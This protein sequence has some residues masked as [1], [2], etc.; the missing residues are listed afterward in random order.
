MVLPFLIGTLSAQKRFDA[1][2]P[3]VYVFLMVMALMRAWLLGGLMYRLQPVPVT[4]GGHIRNLLMLQA[5]F[6]VAAGSQG[7]LPAAFFVLLSFLFAR[8][9]ARFYSS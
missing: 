6:C 7:L 8:R 1:F 4:V 5:C 2:T 3:T 9:A